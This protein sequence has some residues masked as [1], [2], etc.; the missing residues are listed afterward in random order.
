MLASFRWWITRRGRS[1][2]CWMTRRG[3]MGKHDEA[4]EAARG[5]TN[6]AGGQA[7]DTGG[8]PDEATNRLEAEVAALKDQAL[9]YAAEVENMRRRAE[10]EV[11]D[12]RAFAIQ[13]FARD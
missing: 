10:R 5:A 3:V 4:D 11:N 9:R 7:E 2:D 1:A 12:A 6:G 8:A 13:K